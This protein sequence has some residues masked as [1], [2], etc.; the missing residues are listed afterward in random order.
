MN[1]GVKLS[2]H[3]RQGILGHWHIREKLWG[4]W[5][6]V[7]HIAH[8][9]RMCLRPS[10]QRPRSRRWNCRCVRTPPAQLQVT[11][12]APPPHSYCSAQSHWCRRPRPSRRG[13]TTGHVI[14]AALL[15][16]TYASTSRKSIYRVEYPPRGS[17]LCKKPLDK[18][19]QANMVRH[20][21]QERRQAEFVPHV[22]S[23]MGQLSD[24]CTGGSA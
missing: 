1:G 23:C 9:C 16:R 10:H 14:S 12:A 19:L 17:W 6:K 8:C 24:C 2:D 4:K 5:K 3:L 15:R 11:V 21:P 18:C 20:F 7:L 13:T 22:G